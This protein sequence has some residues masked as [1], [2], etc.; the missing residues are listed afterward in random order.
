[1]TKQ[2]LDK[3]HQ[4]LM[5]TESAEKKGGGEGGGECVGGLVLL[6]RFLW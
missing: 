6:C 5:N 2:A 4:K 3:H 1:M